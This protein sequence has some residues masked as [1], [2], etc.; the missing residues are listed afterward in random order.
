[1]EPGP[2]TDLRL[3]SNPMAPANLRNRIVQGYAGIASIETLDGNF[4]HIPVV[5]VAI[6][7]PQSGKQH[8]IDRFILLRR[9]APVDQFTDGRRERA[10]MAQK[11]SVDSIPKM[12]RSRSSEARLES[13][14]LN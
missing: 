9:K 5:G 10:R 8:L 2:L 12:F 3:A 7:N 11:Y 6:K 13:T 14:R 4:D 1:M